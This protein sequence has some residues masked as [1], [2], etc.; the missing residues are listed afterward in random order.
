MRRLALSAALL[1]AVPGFAQDGPSFVADPVELLDFGVICDVEIAG[2]EPAPGT[3]SGT[4]N[5]V[6]DVQ[7][8]D[9]VTRVVPAQIGLTFG[10]RLEMPEGEAALSGRVVVEHP[11]L[12]PGAVTREVW[13]SEL[14]PG[15][16]LVSLFSFEVAREL[17]QGRWIFRY[18]AGGEVL[19]EQHFDVVEPAAAPHVMDVCFEAVPIS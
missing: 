3:E 16:A 10:V 8:M 18:E 2:R 17:V 12:G 9:V 5:I 6:G 11:P 19:S 13:S 1:W 7:A 14:A 4:L 15:G